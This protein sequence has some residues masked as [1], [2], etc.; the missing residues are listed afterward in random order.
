LDTSPA[1]HNYN[2]PTQP[3]APEVVV[4]D[5]AL[6]VAVV[7]ESAGQVIDLRS[8]TLDYHGVAA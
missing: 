2:I 3:A 4:F 1:S 6:A 5:D 7:G 8:Q